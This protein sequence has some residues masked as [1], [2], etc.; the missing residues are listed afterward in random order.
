[1]AEPDDERAETPPPVRTR[2]KPKPSSRQ[3][4]RMFDTS[5]EP[6]VRR[7]SALHRRQEEPDYRPPAPSE[8]TTT[9][10]QKVAE[11]TKQSW[12][13]LTTIAGTVGS[14]LITGFLWHNG[15]MDGLR[16]QQAAALERLETRDQ[17]ACEASGQF[18]KEQLAQ[19]S[20]RLDRCRGS[21]EP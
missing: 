1:M 18:V 12:K 9:R 2:P 19:C 13:W 10:M 6:A 21:G 15:Q 17:A 5:D 14:L 11:A 8:G 7:A 4:D 16:E 3:D 20:A